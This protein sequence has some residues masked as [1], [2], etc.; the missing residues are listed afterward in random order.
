MNRTLVEAARTML[1]DARMPKHFWGEAINTAVYVM[2]R[3]V[4]TNKL[5]SPYEEFM[6]KAPNYLEMHPF[7]CDVYVKI[8]DVKR[9]KLDIK[10]E[11]MKFIGYDDE[12]KGYRVANKN[13]VIMV[14]RD[15]VFLDINKQHSKNK[16]TIDKD[17]NDSHKEKL[18]KDQEQ[19]TKSFYYDFYEESSCEEIEDDF[20]D[21]QEELVSQSQ[22]L[23]DQQEELQEE[24]GEHIQIGEET[25][26]EAAMDDPISSR[27]PRRENA[28]QLPSRYDDY[29]VYKS[30]RPSMKEP[31]NF[32]EALECKDRNLWMEAM[33][34]ELEAIKENNT[35]EL[36]ELPKGRKAIGSKWVYKIKR[37][38]KGEV[39]RYKAR[40][41]AKGFSQK[42]GIDYDEVFAPTVRS[43]TFRVLLSEAAAKGYIVKHFD[44]KTAFLN[45]K[46]DEE[47]YMKQPEGFAEGDKVC[48]LR[49]GLYGLKQAARQWNKEINRVL[50]HNG[51]TQSLWDQCLYFCK[52][53]NV[54]NYVLIHVDD[55]LMAGNNQEMMEKLME[56][57]NKHFELKDLGLVKHFLGIEIEKD[58][59]G[60]F[61]I[62]QERYIEDIIERTGMKEAKISVYPLDPGYEKTIK[63]EVLENN[64]EY[65]KLI[66]MLLYLSTNTRPDI[67][68]SIS[69]LSQKIKN[70]SKNDL[71]EVKRVIRY[72]KGTKGLKLKLS[73]LKSCDKGL[74]AYSDANWAENRKDRKSNSGYIVMLNGGTVSWACRKQECVS[75]SSTEAEYIALAETVQEV[76]WIK[77][78]LSEFNHVKESVTIYEDNQSCIKMTE[79]SKFS[80]RSKHI[81]TKYHFIKDL[82]EKNEIKVNYCP[83]VNNVADM[84]TKPLSGEKIKRLR[85][86]GGLSYE[87][88]FE[89]ECCNNENIA[90]EIK[91][92][93][94][95]KER[96]VQRE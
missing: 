88:S 2:N 7:G 20:Y 75:L 38:N 95:S 1:D 4:K 65:Q 77:G 71:N 54:V 60:N 53:N 63:S 66:G 49:K 87:I 19:E 11:K 23:L 32:K 68:A 82:K 76:I 44:V 25:A 47:V 91:R 29:L 70:P 37:D 5:I 61:M 96:E 8:P 3:I 93:E 67:S 13:H 85:S 16:E 30:E 15:V 78:I 74:V 28:G 18:N 50:S 46:I 41:V 48:R 22:E 31:T 21:A 24:Q 84:L 34:E 58:S 92:E 69:I 12:C 45:G 6:N 80:N 90:K 42:F 57:M 35:W 94:S 89:E 27:R 51:Y 39:L 52:E 64:N 73:S 56:N 17:S 86:Y 40:L 81:D 26:N 83:T 9:K 62:S 10:A 43:T 72:L 55:I 14:S 36:M 33:Q 79:N 59:T